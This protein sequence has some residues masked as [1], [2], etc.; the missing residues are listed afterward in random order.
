[1]PIITIQ[2]PYEWYNQKKKIDVYIDNTKVGHVGIDKTVQFEVVA[3][4]HTL[5]LKNQWPARNTIIDVDVSDNRDKNMK[6]K[7]SQ[8]PFWTLFISA[9]FI[10]IT[11]PLIR[12]YF[13]IE[14]FWYVQIP[15]IAFVFI[16]IM[17]VAS[18]KEGLRLK[19]LN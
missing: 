18:K 11:A 14:S 2:R 10:S 4:Q 3:G 5:M 6:M 9:A 8:W 1:M 13:N 7:S 15:M 19:V 16:S 12:S 17:L